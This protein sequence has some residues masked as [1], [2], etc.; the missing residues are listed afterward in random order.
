MAYATVADLREYG[1]IDG[2]AD[3]YLLE[4]LI[5]R[6]QKA[7]DTYI[8]RIFEASADTTRKFTVGVDTDGLMLYLDEDLASITTV[9]TDADN[10]SP[11]TLTSTEYITHPRNIT[12]YYALEILSSSSNSWTYTTDPENG[13]T[14]KGRWA[15]S[16]TAPD[17][18]IHACIRL[19]SYY[20]AQKDAS[21]F[22]V[23][24]IPDAG[25]I[26]TPQGIPADVKMILNPYRKLVSMAGG[27]WSP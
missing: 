26:Q 15:Y 17:D 10:A 2:T 14:V 7:I 27:R 6:A 11:T 20:Y 12:P 24:A 5:T 8:Q 3:D 25:I 16:T 13:I 18:I 21:V 22:D 9:T 19:V 23:T 1:G 4:A